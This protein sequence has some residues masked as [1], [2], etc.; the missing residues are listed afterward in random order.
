MKIFWKLLAGMLTTILLSF[1]IFGTALLQSLLDSS[2]D[3]ETAQ[4]MDE[5]Q[6]IRYAFLASVEGL[7]ESYTLDSRTIEQLAK[8]VADNVGNGEHEVR[9]YDAQGRGIYPAN[10]QAG[11]LYV[12]LAKQDEDGNNCVWQ[13]TQGAGVRRMEVMTRMDCAGHSYYLKITRNIQYVYDNWESSYR[14]Y[15]I[16]LILL[17]VLATVFSVLFAMGFTSP[18]RKLSRA[19]QAFSDGDYKKRVQPKGNDE[20]ALLMQDFNSMADRLECNIKELEEHSRRQ[21]EFTGAFAHELKTPLT[22]I[23]GYAEMIMTMEMSDEERR[24]AADYIYRE[25]KRLERL[26]YKMM[27]LIRIGKLGPCMEKVDMAEL[28]RQLE[29]FMKV[30]TEDKKVQLTVDMESGSIEG[31]SD[32]LFSLLGNL[33]DNSCKACSEQGRI[34]VLGAWNEKLPG[35]QDRNRVIGEEQPLYRI[36]VEDNGQGIPESEIERVT[37]AFYMVDKSRA[38]KNGGA[39]LGM[40]I[41]SQI[42]KAHLATWKIESKVG[43][44]TCITMLFP[45]QQEK[46]EMLCEKE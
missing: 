5:V 17:T 7:E 6:M 8:S 27:E 23:I 34:R 18:I 13:M 32:L 26:S 42:L 46:G 1:T 33:I 40:A 39:G 19:T 24:M 44:G 41:C 3:R 10:E 25:G 9:V 2:L 22:S 4:S 16:A 36:C 35:V 30:K 11:N 38:R 21:E 12:L 31:D 37:E 28:G 29:R 20:V 15:R 14:I 45:A 43:E